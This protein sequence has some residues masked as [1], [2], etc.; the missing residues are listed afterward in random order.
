M[1]GPPLV[2]T[3]STLDPAHAEI[4]SANG[5][6]YV[7][8]LST[9]ESEIEEMVAMLPENQ[10]KLVTDHDS[11]SYFA[12][13][14]GFEI[15]GTVIPGLTT[16]SEPSAQ[17]IAALSEQIEAEGVPAIF[18]GTTINDGLAQ[19]IASDTG[20]QVVRLYTGSL[21]EADGPAATYVDLMRYNVEAIVSAL[22]P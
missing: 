17:E 20:A 8:A 3:L 19:Q 10:R 15:V 4:Y 16:T 18:V 11:F 22:Q 21:S 5:A 12:Y 14:Y 13:A 7:E 6:A 9:L 1:G 2:E